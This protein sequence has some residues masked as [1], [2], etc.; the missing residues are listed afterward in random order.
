[1]SSEM[2]ESD[3][4]KPYD[5]C[6]QEDLQLS[7]SSARALHV[8]TPKHLQIG[9]VQVGWIKLQRHRHQYRSYSRLPFH[10]R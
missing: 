7:L 10:A 2:A 9:P 3:S 8:C 1:M 5:V 6:I 4:K